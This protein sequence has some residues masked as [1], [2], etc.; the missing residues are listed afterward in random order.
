MGAQNWDQV[1]MTT[2]VFYGIASR[3]LRSICT[4]SVPLLCLTALAFIILCIPSSIASSV[5]WGNES[6][7]DVSSSRSS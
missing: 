2:P 5:E 1:G 6:V 3:A 7:Y 4:S